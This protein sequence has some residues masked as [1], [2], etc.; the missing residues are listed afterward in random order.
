M[1]CAARF[2]SFVWCFLCL[3]GAAARAEPLKVT[4]TITTSG[5]FDCLSTIQCSGEG[6]DSVTFGSGEDTATLTFTGVSS[7]FEVTNRVTPVTLGAFELMASDGFVFPV[8]PTNPRRPILRFDFNVAQAQPVVASTTR[9]M[10]FGPG[11]RPS[12]SIQLASSFFALP[13]GSTEP[14][15]YS[16][17][18]YTIKPFPFSIEPGHITPLTA[19]VGAVP[20][21]TTILLVGTGLASAVAVRRRRRIRAA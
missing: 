8:F 14:F 5:S 18:V 12:L 3:G 15:N 16:A 10:R 4:S 20:E 9:I 19:Q 17:I 21:P 7:T 1:K 13:I 2:G 11:G 6:T